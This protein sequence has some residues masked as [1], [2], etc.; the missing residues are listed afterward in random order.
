MIEISDRAKKPC[1][2]IMCPN[3]AEGSERYCPLCISKGYNEHKEYKKHR[4]DKYEQAI[5]KSAR[6]K[7]IREIR[8][9]INPLC[10]ECEKQ[11]MIAIARL[12]DH[13]NPIK[14]GGEPYDLD[15]TQSLCYSCHNRKTSNE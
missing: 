2:T 14:H 4:T 8:L 15:N 5:Y 13:I 7:K 11:G 9:Q 10:Q 6:W 1:T 3:L 12:V